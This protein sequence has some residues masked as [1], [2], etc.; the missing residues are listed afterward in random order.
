MS[1]TKP[2]HVLL[3]T[4]GSTSAQAALVA[5]SRFPWPAAAHASVVVAKHVRSEFQRSILLTALDRTADITA[6]RAARALRRRWPD[7]EARV[8]NA[9]PVEGIVAEARRVKA[10]VIVL[11]WRGHGALRRLLAGSVSRGVARR[12]PCSVLVVG[13]SRREFRRVVIG[14]DGSP[15]AARAV[16]VVATLTPSRVGRV[17]L[18]CAV[19]LMP[20]PTQGLAPASLRAN[21]KAEVAR[22]NEERR[23]TAR[24]DLA[25]AAK[26]LSAAGWKVDQVLTDGA[27]LRA[28]LAT[29][30]KTRADVLVVGARGVTGLR[31]L[32]LGSVAEGATH[33][34]PVP[35]L[36]V[37]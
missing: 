4:D 21:V 31:H 23:T 14:I 9:A 16:D 37:R 2:F 36:I 8:A 18:M 35:V 10:D 32:L 17:T 29:V 1:V 28:L 26:Q 19:D 15:H 27:P 22:I 34:C 11:G 13:Q 5:A 25:R 20:V 12:A 3:A 6:L 33:A 24:T 30:T 7:V